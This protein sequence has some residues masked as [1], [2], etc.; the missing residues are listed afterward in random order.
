MKQNENRK[1]IVIEI[2]DDTFTENPAASGPGT[3]A[4]ASIPKKKMKTIRI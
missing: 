1:V 4:K 2:D 3:K